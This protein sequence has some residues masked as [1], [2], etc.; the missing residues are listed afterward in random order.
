MLR[1]ARGN[2]MVLDLLVQDWHRCGTASLALS[3]GAM[4]VSTH[5]PREGTWRALVDAIRTHAELPRTGTLVEHSGRSWAG[6]TML[7]FEPVDRVDRGRTVSLG[8]TVMYRAIL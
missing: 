2:P 8:Y 3:L 6:V 4:T 7:R 5:G 1:A